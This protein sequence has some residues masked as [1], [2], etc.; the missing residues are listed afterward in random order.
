[1]N[2]LGRQ[3]LVREAHV[4]DA[5]GMSLGGSEID[6]PPLAQDIE[7]TLVLQRVLL[8]EGSDG[9]L[10]H[11]H[12]PEALKVDLHIEVPGVA[13]DGPIFHLLEVRRSNDRYISRN[14]DEDVPNG[15]R[16]AHREHLEAIHNRL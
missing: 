11:R 16:L 1:M 3:G 12:P 5:G 15:G 8:E 10:F 4:H 13:K 7:A 2:V 14:R 6:E 9:P